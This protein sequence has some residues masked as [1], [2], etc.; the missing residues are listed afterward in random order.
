[1][2]AHNTDISSIASFVETMPSVMKEAATYCALPHWFDQSL[3]SALI[4]HFTSRNGGSGGVFAQLLHLPFVYSHTDE[5]WQ[6][7]VATR[8]YFINRLR[9]KGGIRTVS[10]FLVSY[11]QHQWDEAV[12]GDKRLTSPSDT[13]HEAD[14]QLR[15]VQWQLAY[16]WAPLD[17]P[18]AMR[19]LVDISEWA[20]SRTSR[21]PDHKLI[22]DVFHDQQR[23]LS[24][25]AVEGCYL[26]GRYAYAQRH[27]R[28]AEEKFAYVWEHGTRDLLIT[29]NAGHLLAVIRRRKGRQMW[30]EDAEAMLRRILTICERDIGLENTNAKVLA[31][32]VLNS[33]GATLVQQG[34]SAHLSEAEKMLRR[35][36]TMH[37]ELDDLSGTSQVLNSL[38]MLL[39]HT[40]GGTRLA[41]AEKLLRR[42][43]EMS[44]S[45]GDD[46]SIAV[47]QS[48]LAY[49][50]IEQG[51][52]GRFPEAQA[53]LYG[54]LRFAVQRDDDYHQALVLSRLGEL[55]L[56]WGNQSRLREAEKCFKRSL[57]LWEKEH[58]IRGQYEAL[59]RLAQILEHTERP[60][61]G[62]TLRSRAS[63]LEL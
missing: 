56:K 62:A 16:H 25:Y 36:L 46:R 34:G 32:R 15:R 47:Q 8:E 28:V 33:L 29:A 57:E 12:E 14:W 50:L 27:W 21:L 42:A 60:E 4:R 13:A 24:E 31:S 20:G 55:L 59:I 11:L 5:T 1:M 37:E 48:S 30:V 63:R 61:E 18:E 39:A 7:T 35:S 51:D 9:H 38:G 23:F 49:V 44:R 52:E 10:R 40:G 43:L 45:S 17:A 19:R 41:E 3:G 58:N 26:E 54:S 22:V 2:K 53:L 6:Y